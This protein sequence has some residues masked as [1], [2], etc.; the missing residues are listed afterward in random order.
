ML[1][2]G[3]VTVP[4]QAASHKY[5]DGLV[6]PV[7]FTGRLREL[8][9]WDEQALMGRG[10][11][12]RGS[13]VVTEGR[14]Y[15]APAATDEQLQAQDHAAAC[16]ALDRT[17]AGR[18]ATALLFRYLTED[19]RESAERLR[20]FD[21]ILWNTDHVEGELAAGE[22]LFFN[23]IRIRFLRGYPNGNVLLM[24]GAGEPKRPAI[25]TLC[26]HPITPYPNDDIVLSQLMLLRTAPDEFLSEA[27]ASN[28]S[29]RFK[30]KAM[31]KPI[32]APRLVVPG[33]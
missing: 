25:A 12:R 10:L 26:L 31:Y 17:P 11:T 30:F 2:I 33:A 4:R 23:T 15:T 14:R 29:G 24:G 21:H 9:D 20:Y 22:P 27:N 7:R 8:S 13:L 32:T 19:Q 6:L 3:S 16:R 5:A 18:R 28:A 1:R